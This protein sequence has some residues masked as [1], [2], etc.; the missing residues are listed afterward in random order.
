M[1]DWQLKRHTSARPCLEGLIVLK[2]VQLLPAA[3]LMTCV[4]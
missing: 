3:M 2:K 1:A 4:P